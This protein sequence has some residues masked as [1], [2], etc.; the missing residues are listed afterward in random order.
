MEM[1]SIEAPILLKCLQ[2]LESRGALV[3]AH[4][5]RGVAG[6]VFRYAIATGR[7][8]EIHHK[9]LKGRYRRQMALT[10]LP[11]QNLS[12]WGGFYELSIIL[13]DLSPFNVL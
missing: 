9:I 4:R 5:V 13:K 6:Q 2:R 11:L 3:S 8:G 10:S 1:D 12:K 7:A